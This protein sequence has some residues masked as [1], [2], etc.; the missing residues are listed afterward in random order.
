[1]DGSP[2]A[3]LTMIRHLVETGGEIMSLALDMPAAALDPGG[4]VIDAEHRLLGM[5]DIGRDGVACVVP[6]ALISRAVRPVTGEDVSG[7]VPAPLL[8]R[9][10]APPL[11]PILPPAA[12]PAR[13]VPPETRRGWLGVALQPIT[14]PESLAARA[15][16]PSGRMVVS[17]TPG[18]P[19]ERAGM[20]VGDVLL[21]V[22]GHSASGSHALRA[23]LGADRIGSRVEVR[24]M[25]D[26]AIQTVALTVAVQPA[27]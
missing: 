19:A 6:H 11:Q 8:V 10:A 3:R 13:P 12:R 17:I 16:Q 23:F 7:D 5:A 14:V 24:L 21:A 18:G 1:M 26:G 2:A 25:R 9:P 22:N 27:G 4:P 15:G 20:R